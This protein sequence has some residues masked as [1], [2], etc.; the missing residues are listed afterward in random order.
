MRVGLGL[1]KLTG[2]ARAQAD[3]AGEEMAKAYGQA[4]KD[5]MRYGN[6]KKGKAAAQKNA[7]NF[8]GAM[9]SAAAANH[10][11]AGSGWFSQIKNDYWDILKLGPYRMERIND[12]CIKYIYV[13][14]E[15]KPIIEMIVDYKTD[16]P[17]EV[18]RTIVTKRIN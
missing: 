2:K 1:D 4:I 3:K 14:K 6:S 7:A 17:Y 5:D 15:M 13:N 10:D 12:T 8:F 18:K 16:S 9:L 11:D